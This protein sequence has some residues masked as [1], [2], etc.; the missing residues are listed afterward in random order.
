MLFVLVCLARRAALV[1]NA[2][3]SEYAA[4]VSEDESHSGEKGS[5]C[6]SGATVITVIGSF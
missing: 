3:T 6:K 4:R 1:Y 2:I 5:R